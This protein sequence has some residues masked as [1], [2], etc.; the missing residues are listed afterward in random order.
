MK[1]FRWVK[2]LLSSQLPVSMFFLTISVCLFLGDGKQTVVEEAGV[3]GVLG[4]YIVARYYFKKVREPPDTIIWLWS[5]ILLYL[6]ITTIFSDD[7]SYSVD[8]TIRYIEAFL[9]YYI[10]YCYSDKKTYD[11]FINLLEYFVVFAII[12]AVFITLVPGLFEFLA[13]TN[14]LYPTYGHNYIAALII[15]IFPLVVGRFINNK[16][17]IHSILLFVVAGALVFSFSRGA[18]VAA[19]LYLTF[20]CVRHWVRE[21]KVLKPAVIL[22]VGYVIVAATIFIIPHIF[23]KQLAQNTLLSRQLIKI[24]IVDSRISYWKQALAAIKVR[25]MFGTGAGTFNLLS[26]RYE[27]GPVS[28]SWYAHSFPLQTLA[29]VGVIGFIG[30]FSIFGYIVYGIAFSVK[31]ESTHNQSLELLFYGTVLTL[32]YSIYEFN[33]DFLVMWFILW[34]S[35][36]VLSSL[37]TYTQGNKRSQNLSY[38]VQLFC[39]S[40][41]TLYYILSVVSTSTQVFSKS[42]PY[43]FVFESYNADQ[44]SH[45]IDSVNQKKQILPEYQRNLINFFHKQNPDVL[46]AQG[47]YKEAFYNN[48]ED[49]STFKKYYSDLVA[50]NKSNEIT[51]LLY[52]LIHKYLPNNSSEK[53]LYTYL[54]I[55]EAQHAYTDASITYFGM[56]TNMREGVAKLLYYFGLENIKQNPQMTTVFWETSKNLTP[57]FGHYYVELSSLY[58]AHGDTVH[59]K[60]ILVDCRQYPYAKKQCE[61]APWPPLSPGLLKEKI[62]M[63]PKVL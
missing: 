42:Q 9:L 63:F 3:A 1:L 58:Y 36:G 43:V 13:P 33:L 11:L 30:V 53:V 45:Y 12:C 57:E 50:N 5:A 15:F 48:P 28:Y 19:I 60:Q 10:F 26:K 27:N 24:S 25:P 29:E 32:F 38:W 23:N 14:L 34:A 4:L 51:E 21:R 6:C 35:L 55:C 39:L 2:T 54:K 59:A 18:I 56:P 20:L 62:Q 7:V 31:N 41:I 47:L 8:A 16:N 61:E 52:M 37:A 46:F 22:T 40:I 17:S 44:I 49:V